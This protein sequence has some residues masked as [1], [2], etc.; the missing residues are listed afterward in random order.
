VSYIMHFIRR[1]ETEYCK[2][3]NK[4]IHAKLSHFVTNLSYNL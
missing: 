3:Y 1:S 4:I 2:V